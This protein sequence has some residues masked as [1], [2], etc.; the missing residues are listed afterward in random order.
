VKRRQ[1]SSAHRRPRRDLLPRHAPGM[2]KSV[3]PGNILSQLRRAARLDA[4]KQRARR[5]SFCWQL[6]FQY[7]NGIVVIASAVASNI[8]NKWKKRILFRI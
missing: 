3:A 1:Q 2:K 7:W 4:E 6:S 8:R 5:W